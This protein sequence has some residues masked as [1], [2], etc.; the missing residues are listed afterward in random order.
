M[1]A[2]AALL[3]H[4][5]A[6][7]CVRML[8]PRLPTAPVVLPF[9]V[10]SSCRRSYINKEN[11][12]K[13]SRTLCLRVR[14]ANRASLTERT[15]HTSLNLSKLDA[16]GAQAHTGP[17]RAVAAMP[18]ARIFL[19]AQR[20]QRL[21]CRCTTRNARAGPKRLPRAG[22]AV[23]VGWAAYLFLYWLTTTKKNRYT[24]SATMPSAR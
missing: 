2:Y 16:R 23:C 24:C 10:P 22:I 1:R 18:G 11:M 14:A 15:L 13:I 8:L 3:R 12:A 21:C 9:D 7:A 5:P 6:Q 19:P 4:A 20:Q 17:L